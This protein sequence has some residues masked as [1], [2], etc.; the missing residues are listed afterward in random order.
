MLLSCA[1]LWPIKLQAGAAQALQSLA[2]CP[3]QL[4]PCSI[5]I[6]YL[7]THLI[8]KLKI[9]ILLAVLPVSVCITEAMHPS[10]PPCPFP[11]LSGPFVNRRVFGKQLCVLRLAYRLHMQPLQM[12]GERLNAE[13]LW[14]STVSAMPAA[15]LGHIQPLQ[16]QESLYLFRQESHCE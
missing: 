10:A 14:C 16:G 11:C 12:G 13:A 5:L 4:H 7:R 2:P 15:N 6:A 9:C 8:I 1:G 3:L